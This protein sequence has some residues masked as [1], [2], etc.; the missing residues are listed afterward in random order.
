MKFI[1]SYDNVDGWSKK[2]L[3]LDARVTQYS[4]DI[5]IVIFVDTVWLDQIIYNHS[6]NNSPRDYFTTKIKPTNHKPS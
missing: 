2:L 3:I 6:Y 1:N 5:N 4:T